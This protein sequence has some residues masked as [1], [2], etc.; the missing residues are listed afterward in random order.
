MATWS[1]VI[2]NSGNGILNEWVNGKALNFDGAAAGQGTVAEKAMMAQTALVSQKQTASLLGGEEVSMGI[3]LKIRIAAPETAYTLNQYGVWASVTG[4]TSVMIALF[5]IE[6]GIPIP[7]KTESPDFVYT[8]YALV[9]CSNAGTWTVNVDTS[10]SVTVAEMTAAIAESEQAV[11]ANLTS[12]I[13][14]KANPHGVTA[15]QIGAVPTSRNVNGKAL[16]SDVTL[17]ASD[18]GAIPSSQKG[19]AGGVASLGSDGKV[20][21]G[22]LPDMDY[23]P[24]GSAQ[25][26]QSNLNAHT[27]NKSNPHGVT[28]A[29]VGAIPASQKGAAGGVA[30]LDSAGKV[31]A[32]QLPSY[33]DDVLEYPNKSSFPGTGEDGKIYVAEDTNLTYRWSG[34]QYVEISPSLALGETS[35]TAYRGDRGKTAYDHSQKSGNPHGTT[36]AQVGALPLTGGTLS[37]NLTGKYI[38]GTWL[39]AT[40]ITDLNAV[41]TRFAVIDGSGWLYYRSAAEMLSDLGVNDAIQSAIG[42][43]MAA[44]Y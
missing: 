30:E 20:P 36:A 15:S 33:V 12:H 4:G 28:A 17:S 5:Q 9:A 10:T 11:Q 44:S 37:G 16:S 3:R 25:G 27:N 39:Q 22:Q 32:A 31:P 7:S 21:A 13:N 29:Q 2:T 6:E 40:A 24:A 34:S 23:D 26:V 35:S 38:T 18:V 8:F 43:A 19:A 14:N 41:S 42:N 1:G